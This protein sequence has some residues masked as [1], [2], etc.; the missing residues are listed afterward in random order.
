MGNLAGQQLFL[1]YKGGGWCDFWCK[2]PCQLAPGMGIMAL[3]SLLEKLGQ[4]A[5]TNKSFPQS[6]LV[7]YLPLQGFPNILKIF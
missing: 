3:A 7:H 6:V 2:R 4:R 1:G 5:S